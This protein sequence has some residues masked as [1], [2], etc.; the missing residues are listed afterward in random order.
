MFPFL[1]RNLLT[2]TAEG[3]EPKKKRM[4]ADS[5]VTRLSPNMRNQQEFFA[6]MKGEQVRFSIMKIEY[7]GSL[8]KT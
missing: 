5:D 6:N 1:L 7:F 4:K 8:C 3:N 2:W